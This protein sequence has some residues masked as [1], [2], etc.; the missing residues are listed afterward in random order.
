MSEP[1]TRI[2]VSTLR[3]HG[4]VNYKKLSAEWSGYAIYIGVDFHSVRNRLKDFLSEISFMF[5]RDG[6]ESSIEIMIRC[7]NI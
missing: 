2:N 7:E 3:F 4:Q 6:V 1:Y 5:S